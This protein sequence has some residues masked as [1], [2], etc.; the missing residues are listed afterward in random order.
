MTETTPDR[1]LTWRFDI[2]SREVIRDGRR[3]R[4]AE[5]PFLVLAALVEADGG[6]VTRAALQRRLWSDDTFVDFD[7]NLN[8]AVA[9]LRH[10]FGES[11]RAPMFIE[12]VPKVG[13]RLIRPP[14]T[15]AGDR[16]ALEAGVSLAPEPARARTGWPVSFIGIASGVVAVAAV[17]IVGAVIWS[18]PAP[19]TGDARVAAV[20]PA[21][22]AEL[23][24]GRYLRAEYRAT[25]HDAARLE[26]ARAA[27]ARARTL[28]P[29]VEAPADAEEADT[30]VELAFAGGLRFRDGL[31]RARALARS[32]LARDRGNATAMRVSGLAA[33]FLDWDFDGARAWIDRADARAS[34]DARTALARATVFAAT[35]QADAAVAAAERAVALDPESHF[36][37]ADLALFYLAAGRVQDAADT[38]RRVLEVAPDFAPALG[39]VVAAHER[40]GQWEPAARAAIALLR[41]TKAPAGVLERASQ[42]APEGAVRAWHE[43][44]LAR[45]RQAAG[46]GQAGDLAL[47]LAVRLAAIGDRDQALDQLERALVRREAML[48]FVRAFPEFGTLKGDPRFE[49]LALAIG[50]S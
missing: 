44:D 18:R 36:V 46:D 33:L 25:H 8:S 26:E 21:A 32:A 47:A 30:I 48:V 11:G 1:G 20:N 50:R 15:A 14:S 28:D 3:T 5:K 42:A 49:R 43:W 23:Q 22:L 19:P 27:F 6:V 40:L 10:V 38:S 7:N 34:D 9:T 35:G 37:R 45:V 2:E 41:A 13:Y 16:T 29:S 17:A 4:L 31:T 12:T 24:R 39:N